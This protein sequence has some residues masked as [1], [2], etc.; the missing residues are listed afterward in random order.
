MKKTIPSPQ[1][2]WEKEKKKLLRIRRAVDVFKRFAVLISAVGVFMF[3]YVI[4]DAPEIVLNGNY[5]AA[6]FACTTA[7]LFGPAVY[8]AEDWI[9]DNLKEAKINGPKI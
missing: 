6:L 7:I 4:A 5:Y 2:K 8:F 3:L 9:K 1:Q